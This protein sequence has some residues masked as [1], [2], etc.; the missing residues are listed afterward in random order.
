[1]AIE[2]T[3]I[4]QGGYLFK[5]GHKKLAVDPH[6][7]DSLI[8]RNSWTRLITNVMRPEELK[9]DLIICTHDHMDHLDE[10]TLKYTD[11]SKTMYGGPRTC[12]EHMKK[13][14]LPSDRLS[15]LNVGESINLGKA[16]VNGV[17]AH[18]I[19][20]EQMVESIGLVIEYEGT[21]LYIVGDSLYHKKLAEV[22]SMKPDILIC[23][24]N[25]RL[26]NMN[27]KEAAVLAKELGVKVAIP[28]HY[29]MFAENT[30]DPAY[31]KMMLDDNIQY[32]EF[33]LGRPYSIGE[34]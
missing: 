1:M 12:I 20:A 6:L 2:I 5:L 26:G 11:W 34:M 24:I 32:M 8:K 10:E 16:V 15:L 4:G 3:W 28:S 21:K 22:I 14:N 17:Y 13:I 33:E 30:E 23:C 9:A 18:H 19:Y 31:F 27:Y 7:S 25:G 29:G